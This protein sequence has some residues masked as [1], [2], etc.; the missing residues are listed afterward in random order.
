[1]AKFSGIIIGGLEIAA[2][3]LIDAFVPGGAVFGNML[4]AAGVG[5]VVGNVGTLLTAPGGGLSTASRNPIQPWNVI[6][7]RSKVGGTIVYINEH[8]DS[9]KYLDLVF[10]LACHPCQS[11]DALLFDNQRV[12]INPANNS[13]YSP[14]QATTNISTITRSNGVVTVTLSAG[15]GDLQAGDQIIIQNVTGQVT[16]DKSL[17]GK[18]YVAQVI[19]STQFTYLCGGFDVSLGTTGQAK[20][21]WADYRSKVYMEALLGNHT[22]TFTGM[23]TGTPYDGNTSSLVTLSNNPWTANCLLQG[24]TAVFLRLH[25]NDE[26]FSSG[27]P[28]ISFRVH[29]KCDIYDPRAGNVLARPSV[30]LNGW[31]PSAHVGAYEMGV[32]QAYGWGTDSGTTQGYNTPDQATD[33]NFGTAAYVHLSHTHQ[34]AGCIWANFPAVTG[35]TYLNILSAVPS[36]GAGTLRSAGIWYS[37][38]SGTTWTQIYNSPVRGEQWDCI[39]LP[40]GQDPTHI[41]VM[42]FAD[43][44]DDM[45]HYV[46]DI[47][48]AT[49]PASS[50][51]SENAAL[52]IADYLSNNTFGFKARYGSEIPAAQLITAANLC[53][54][55]VP[56]ASGA[57]EP[58]YACNGQFQ[59]STSRGE[60]L[61]NLLTSCGGRL[62]YAGGQFVIH[63]AAWPGTSLTLGAKPITAATLTVWSAFPATNTVGAPHIS[64]SLNGGTG[65]SDLVAITAGTYTLRADSATI[66]AIPDV[67]QFQ[68]SAVVDGTLFQTGLSNFFIYDCYLDV[69]YADGS[70]ARLRPGS[71]ASGASTDGSTVTNPANALDSDTNPPT[72]YATIN[73][74]HTSGFATGAVLTLFDFVSTGGGAPATPDG[75]AAGIA[76]SQG[77]LSHLAGPFRWKSKVQIRDLYNGVKGVYVSPANGWQSSDF[78]PYAQDGKH[79]YTGNA[80]YENDANLAADGGDRRW[81]DIQ[82]PFTISPSTAQRLAKIELLRRRQQGTGTFQFSTSLYNLTALDVI[83]LTLPYLGWTN[84]LLEINAHR[85]TQ[86]KVQNGDAE[87]TLLGCE[88]DLQETSPS[89]YSWTTSEELTPQ[90]FQQLA[91]P[92]NGANSTTGAPTALSA[93]SGTSTSIVGADGVA[94]SRILVTWTAPTDGYVLAGGHI[95][96]QYQKSGATTWTGLPSVDPSVTQIYIDSVQDAQAYLVQVRSVNAGGVASAWVQAGPVTVS[97]TASSLASA[98]IAQSGASSGQTLIWNGTAWTPTTAGAV[99]GLVIDG[100]GSVPTTGA[101]GFLQIPYAC[102]LT[103][104]TLL[105]DVSSSAQITISKGAYSAYPAVSSIVASAPPALASAQ[106][107][108]S[109]TLTGWTTAIAAGDVLSFNLDSVSTCTRLTL[110]LQVTRS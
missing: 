48:L 17:N 80:T 82:L 13:S 65:W 15:L 34:Y 94:R 47:D 102:T 57:T 110:E 45:A 10:V 76:A 67:T 22:A 61:Q 28:Q 33:G 70:T 62:T 86:N 50:G 51:Y 55:S 26:V 68:V 85:L 58:R 109:A 100:A 103:G 11:V 105:A 73:R 60:V 91:T 106:K 63:P 7:G 52:C 9:D 78:P 23:T 4:I 77:V 5:S 79:G 49:G 108:T 75:S 81:L 84:K 42:A 107:N 83:Q 27:L 97:G 99:I 90:G 98:S 72:T 38:D 93:T 12:L 87:A 8:G 40:G 25:Y 69:T 3:V 43:S 64:Y 19:T 2:G 29:G 54:E 30:L 37:L 56:L 88:L 36:L 89:V 35:A 95:E 1:M 44:H 41:Q 18:W 96:V 74:F 6:Y 59:L 32:P 46:Y 20:T 92:A 101:K 31:G 53:D 71:T 104:W 14:T 21:C 66:G 39:T 24:R 16:N